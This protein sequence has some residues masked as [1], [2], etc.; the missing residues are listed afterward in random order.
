MILNITVI[1][2]G[3]GVVFVFLKFPTHFVILFHY[4][5]PKEKYYNWVHHEAWC[6]KWVPYWASALTLKSD[7]EQVAADMFMW[8]YKKFARTIYYKENDPND[9]LLLTW[10]RWY[11]Q[12]YEG[13]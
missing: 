4:V 1:Q 10:R 7:F 5:Q 3:A 13:T 9:I 6:S 8:E 12:H 11:S 2:L